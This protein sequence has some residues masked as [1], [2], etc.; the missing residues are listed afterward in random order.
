MFYNVCFISFKLSNVPSYIFIGVYIPP[1]DSPYADPAC[2]ARL[3]TL[4]MENLR[5]GVIP[6]IGG[7]FNSRIGNM[8]DLR[9]NWTYFPNCDTTVNNYGKT[10]FIDLCRTCKINPVNNLKYKGKYLKGDFTYIK[11]RKASQINLLTNNDG[12]S[13]I[14][15]FKI[16]SNDWHLS[17]HRPISVNLDLP[18]ITNIQD[19]YTRA[20]DLNAKHFLQIK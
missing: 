19:I 15:D 3:N 10:Y 11:G 12:L 6:F 2:F 8:E 5:K 13:N 4:L 7:D 14:Q 18:N 9:N 16:I 1:E 20:K 17:D